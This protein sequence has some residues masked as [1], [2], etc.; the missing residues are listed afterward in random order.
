MGLLIEL[1][2]LRRKRNDVLEQLKELN[3]ELGLALAENDR[4]TVDSLM[5]QVENEFWP[6]LEQLSQAIYDDLAQGTDA[7]LAEYVHQGKI[8]A[9]G[10]RLRFKA[11]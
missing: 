5:R 2:D 8:K 1:Q 4:S 9:A 11:G 6:R 3:V 7:Y 10:A